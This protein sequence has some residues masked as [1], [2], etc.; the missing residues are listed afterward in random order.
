LVARGAKALFVPF[1]AFQFAMTSFAL[2]GV[3]SDQTAFGLILI[4]TVW[5]ES[6]VSSTDVA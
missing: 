4:S 3:P 5:G 6:L 1:S 2:I